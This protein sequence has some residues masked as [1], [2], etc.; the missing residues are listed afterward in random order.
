M[1]PAGV[2][3]ISVAVSV[4][5]GALITSHAAFKLSKK[6]AEAQGKLKEVE[7][8]RKNQGLEVLVVNGPHKLRVVDL[9][10]ELKYGWPGSAA[11][12]GPSTRFTLGSEAVSVLTRSGPPL[13][14]QIEGFQAESWVLPNSMFRIP[15]NRS[16]EIAAIAITDSRIELRSPKNIDSNIE[17]EGIPFLGKFARSPYPSLTLGGT[18]GFGGILNSPDI[19]AEVKEWLVTAWPSTTDSPR[20]IDLPLWEYPK[21]YR[22]TE[23]AL[24]RGPR[25][26]GLVKGSANEIDETVYRAFAEKRIRFKIRGEGLIG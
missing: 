1:V 15:R 7:I 9:H 5:V 6:S 17:P 16:I 2:A 3:L 24:V 14:A 8:A 20:V 19:D 11:Y 23:N 13:P 18:Y 12:G 21:G 10:L 4:S 22:T 26:R 25:V